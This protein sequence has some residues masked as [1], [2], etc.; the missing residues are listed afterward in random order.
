M[1]DPGGCSKG[2][3]YVAVFFGREVHDIV[4]PRGWVIEV[5]K[6]D[7]EREKPVILGDGNRSV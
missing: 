6:V 3:T 5:P 4:C 7:K 1:G 2:P